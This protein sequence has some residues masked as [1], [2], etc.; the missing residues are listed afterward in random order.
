M[1]MY[2]VYESDVRN[3]GIDRLLNGNIMMHRFDSS[4]IEIDLLG[5]TIRQFYAE[6]RPFPPPEEVNAIPIL[7]QQT[8]H[9]QP[10]QMP[11]GDYLAFA[12]NGY[13]VEDWYTSEND[14]RCAAQRHDG[15]GGYGRAIQC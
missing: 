6:E 12:A 4:T 14:P 2:L 7:G 5:N 10:H 15:H 11:N 8:L 1:A 3:S 9:H 13:L